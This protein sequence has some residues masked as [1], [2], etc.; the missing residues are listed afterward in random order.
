MTFRYPGRRLVGKMPFQHASVKTHNPNNGNAA[1]ERA[2]SAVLAELRRQ[3]VLHGL[4]ELTCADVMRAPVI[5]VRA[6]DTKEYAQTLLAR[7]RFKL[8]PVIDA[9]GHLLGVVSHSDL[10]RVVGHLRAVGDESPLPN[11]TDAVESV[12]SSSVAT[13]SSDM[14]LTDVVRLFMA[15]GHHHL[16]VIDRDRR[17]VGMLTQSDLFAIMCELNPMR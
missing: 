12:M 10:R 13:V 2:Q 9:S 14:K 11:G 16:P 6:D 17:I 8:L 1:G 4:L 15:R 3:S 5:T 7:Y